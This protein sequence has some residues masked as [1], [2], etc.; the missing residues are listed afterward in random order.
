MRC[1]TTSVRG[2]HRLGRWEHAKRGGVSRRYQ[3]GQATATL[4][5]NP[6]LIQEKCWFGPH[7]LLVPE[8]S[9][10]DLF[11]PDKVM[12]NIHTASKINPVIN[13][14]HP[15]FRKR[16]RFKLRKAEVIKTKCDI[17]PWMNAWLVVTDH[18]YYALTAANGSFTLTDVPPETYTLQAWHETL[19]KHTQQASVGANQE[20]NVVFEL[21]P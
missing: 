20:T 2:S 11:N 18:P 14:A 7:V 8:G 6:T 17:H 21:K 16:L 12:H 9:T 13:K 1:G 5:K 19:G 15:S 3:P 10:V 4:E